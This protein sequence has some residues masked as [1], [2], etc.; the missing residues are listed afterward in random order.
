MRR[1]SIAGVLGALGL[2]FLVASAALPETDAVHKA[3]LYVESTQQ[4][5]GGFGGFGPGQTMDAIFAIR[6]AGLDPNSFERAGKTPADFV[7]A[8]AGE[9]TTAAAA[10]KAAMGAVAVGLDPRDTGGVDLVGVAEAAYDATTGAYAGDD[11]SQA[12]VILGLA[13]AGAGIPAGAL[14]ALRA[15]Q[16][17]DGGWGFGES[18]ADTTAIV[19]QAMLAAGVAVDDPATG[20]ALEYLRTTQNADAGWGFGGESNTSST[21][22]AI[23]AL[24]AAGEDPESARYTKG[25]ETPVGYLLSLQQ[26]DGSFPG[27]DPAFATNQVIP[28][29]AGK[30]FVEAPVVNVTVT[31]LPTRTPTA[32]VPAATATTVPTRAPL[33]P[34]TGTGAAFED[35][36]APLPLW[37]IAAAIVLGGSLLAVARGR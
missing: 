16:F 34:A 7:V 32:T 12:I 33:A 6:S 1:I 13:R 23:Q 14:Q 5:D 30:T 35:G 21:A 29:L 26:G 8:H 15:H 20:A 2:T 24:L 19:L 22:Y 9:A 3:L 31:A 11:F 28:A 17:E 4:E 25:S 27:Y 18:D 37:A 10:A 36:G